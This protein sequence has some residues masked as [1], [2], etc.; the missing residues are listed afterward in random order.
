[1]DSS[2]PAKKSSF[3]L[4][5]NQINPTGNELGCGAYGRVFEVNYEGTLC[6]AK[7]IHTALLQH[8]GVEEFERI[9]ANFIRECKIWSR[10]RHPYI[11]HFLGLYGNYVRT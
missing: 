4:N 11:V 7:E 5:E 1:M 6:A 10:L 8:A 3:I 9:K 2:A